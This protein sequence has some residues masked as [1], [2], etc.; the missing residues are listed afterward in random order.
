MVWAIKPGQ[1]S[2]PN[3]KDIIMKKDYSRVGLPNLLETPAA[4]TAAPIVNKEELTVN[5]EPIVD[6][7]EPIVNKEEPKSKKKT[8]QEQPQDEVLEAPAE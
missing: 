7:E 4:K 3:K 5:A 8:K 2:K 6:K 1:N